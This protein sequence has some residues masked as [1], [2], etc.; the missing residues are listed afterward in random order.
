MTQSI[1]DPTQSSLANADL[2]PA[3]QTWTWYNI[4]AF[5]MSDVHSAGGYVFAGTLFHSA[6]R[7]GRCSRRCFSAS[8]SF[9][10]WQT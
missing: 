7:A 6:S 10:A 2:L 5:W 8:S 3:K 4:F 9:R 1:P